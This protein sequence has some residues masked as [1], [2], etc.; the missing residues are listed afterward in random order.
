M[1]GC[2]WC[3]KM[4]VQN[5]QFVHKLPFVVILFCFL[6]D[7]Y[8]IN[9]YNFE[10]CLNCFTLHITQCDLTLHHS[11]HHITSHHITS[12]SVIL[13]LSRVILFA[14]KDSQK[15]L[16]I[17]EI[18]YCGMS[19]CTWCGKM[20]VQNQQFVHKLPFVVILFCFLID[21]YLINIYNFELCPNCFTLHITESDIT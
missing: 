1:S 15:V 11:L 2:T 21:F 16:T 5:Q 20:Y 12:Q 13:N 18:D 9:V 14:S 10:L 3:G 17:Q 6:I 7:F 19:G 8:L 4:Y